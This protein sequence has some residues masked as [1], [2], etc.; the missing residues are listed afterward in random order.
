M[1]IAD[2]RAGMTI[3]LVGE[4]DMGVEQKSLFMVRGRDPLWRMPKERPSIPR[5]WSL[6]ARP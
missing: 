1:I 5:L 2:V 6:R 4:H 3:E